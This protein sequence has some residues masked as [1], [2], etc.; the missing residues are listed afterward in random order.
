MGDTN[1]DKKISTNDAALV[2]NYVLGRY[3]LVGAYEKAADTNKDGRLSTNDASLI[4]NHVLGRFDLFAK[5][6][7]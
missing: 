6:E 2:Q 1:G 4:Q 3:A 7:E 5:S